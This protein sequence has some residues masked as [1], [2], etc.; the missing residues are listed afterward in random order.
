MKTIRGMFLVAASPLALCA[1]V[2]HA[3]A[4]I[5]TAQAAAS[6]SQTP[7][8]PAA[9]SDAPKTIPAAQ[10]PATVQEIVVTG[11]RASLENAERVKRKSAVMIDGISSDNIGEMPDVSIS[12]SLIRIAGVT[13]NDTDRGSD[14]VAIRGLGPDLVSTEYDGRVLPTA[15]GVTRRVGLA[16]LPTEGLS[17]AWA[18]KTPDAETIEGGVAGILELESIKPLETTR[19]GLTLVARGL[20]NDT[21]DSMAGAKGDAPY[22]AREEVTYI[23]RPA[24]NFGLAFSWAGLKQFASETGVQLDGWRLGTGA[25]ADLNKDGTPD[26]LPTTAGS[27]ANSFDDVRNS[28]IAMAQWDPISSI[29]VS[30][31]G[32][33]DNDHYVQNTDQYV[34]FNIYNGA[35]EGAATASTVSNAAATSYAG[36]VGGY[37]GIMGV[38]D[39][40]DHTYE[41]GLNVAYHAGRFKAKFDTSWAQAGRDRSTP[42]VN[43]ENDAV[44]GAGQNLPFAYD[45][46]NPSDV[47]FTFSPLAAND[48]NIQQ[49]TAVAQ[50]SR[51]EIAAARGDFTYDIKSFIDSLQWGFRIDHRD[52]TQNVDSQQW[53]F[54][55][56]AARPTLDSSDLARATNP[57]SGA[58]KALGGS[59]AANYPYY[60]FFKLLN[61]AETAPGAIYNPQYA[62]NLASQ[63]EVREMDYAAYG[64][65]NISIGNLTGNVGARWIQTEETVLG[66]AGTTPANAQ[67]EQ[68]NHEYSYL[69]P[70][71]NLRYAFTPKVVGR[72]AASKTLSRDEFGDLSVGDAVNLTTAPV[73]GVVTEKRGNPDLAPFTSKGV[74]IG[75]EWYPSRAMS[76]AFTYYY[77]WV[78]NF[79]TQT[80]TM[81]TVTLTN[82]TVLPAAL[83]TT[84]ND[85]KTEDFRGFELEGRRD[86]TFLPGIWSA[87]GIEGNWNH[88]TTGARDTFTSL[89]G[90]TADVLPINISKNIVN[91]QLYYSRG[92]VDVR[93][94]YRYY[95]PYS[96][97]VGSVYQFQPGGQF[98]FNAGFD[99]RKGLR[100]IASATNIFGTHIEKSSVDYRDMSSD[101]L[102]EHYTYQGREVTLGLRA[103]F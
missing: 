67:H 73:S 72:F 49:A 29:R 37:R 17:S 93:L 53:T 102:L 20:Y 16:G 99:L 21:S 91:A 45:F 86:F 82:G 77:K 48:Y 41:G 19:H 89:V 57:L 69:L 8:A 96:R 30:L 28:I 6:A 62:S 31:D 46:R 15:D 11:T 59:S 3:Q 14:Q 88:N 61:I 66:L 18:Q 64:Q 65:A 12:E 9:A 71:M 94:A 92:G 47:N 97:Q 38:S 60:N 70:S 68:F 25:R 78:N 10:G 63:T 2:A 100:V 76:F 42:G 23:A 90:N 1:S 84:V 22:G 24:P 75:M 39:I 80:T 58:A 55:N 79:T 26:A 35:A 4:P 43:F 81:T 27:F 51:D 36:K 87:I 74:D 44:A 5:A 98:D 13:S 50:T 85:P 101:S 33:Y 95:S 34:G 54:A 103:Q 40:N 7:P 83:T 52:H 56:V 32:L